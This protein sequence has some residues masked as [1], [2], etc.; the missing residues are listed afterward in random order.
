MKIHSAIASCLSFVLLSASA[1]AVTWSGPVG[2]TLV[3]LD[4]VS[5]TGTSTYLSFA[6]TPSGK[7][8]C[9]TATQGI[10]IPSA[11]I[12][13]EHVKSMTS[14][15]TAAFLA[16]KNVRVLWGGTCTTVG[17]DVFGNVTGIIIQ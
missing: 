15:A 11:G 12:S 2:L 6:S 3:E 17:T 7:P 16:G 5:S 1:L 14:L 4:P 8:G 10:M 9:G 13:A